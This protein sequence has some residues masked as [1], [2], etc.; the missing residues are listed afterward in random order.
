MKRNL[1][2]ILALLLVVALLTA[3]GSSEK[4]IP[5]YYQITKAVFPGT[6]DWEDY[7]GHHNCGIL[8]KD[9]GTWILMENNHAK[10]DYA[11]YTVDGNTITFEDPCEDFQGP[12]TYKNGTLT[13]LMWGMEVT[14][15]K[16][17]APDLK[18]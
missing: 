1:A 7:T 8:L 12:A 15:T 18:S 11:H 13:V 6:D 3:C 17:D 14:L 5:G 9:D 10:G 4:D 16:T 2:L